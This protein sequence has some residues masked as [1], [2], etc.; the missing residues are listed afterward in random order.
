MATTIYP[1]SIQWVGLAKEITPG[2][3][4]AAPT[5]W[6]PV[7]SPKYTPHQA[8]IEDN[9]FR[10]DMALTH[11]QVLGT[12]H[13]EVTYKSYVYLDSAYQPFLNILGNP[14]T[15]TGAADPYTHKTALLNTSPGQPNSWTVFLF[16]GAETWQMPGAQASQVDVDIKVAAAA[17]I[18]VTWLGMPATKMASNPTNTPSTLPPMPSWNTT[19]TVGGT[20]LSIYS[21]LKI[22][23]K[24]ETAPIFTLDGTGSPYVILDGG[25][26]VD[27]DMT[28]VYTGYTGSDI[29]RFLANTQPSVVAKLAPAGDATHS[30]TWQ[31][32]EFGYKSGDIQGNKH[33]EAVVKG[34]ALS[35]TTDAI[36]GG[37]SPLQVVLLS[38][39]SAA[40]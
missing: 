20:Q 28:A 18:S 7:M 19:V 40:Y 21:D 26:S 3:A 38:S 32:S 5:V 27:V 14:D 9:A 37:T 17:E 12:R 29:A 34:V 30:I 13:D 1:E 33:I 4:V 39:A 15:V 36:G 23:C 10:G 11:A 35:N 2:T 25:L 8:M 24:R 6:V 22:T 31:M 16:N